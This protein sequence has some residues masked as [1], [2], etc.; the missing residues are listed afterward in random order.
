MGHAIESVEVTTV[1]PR[2][3]YRCA[4]NTITFIV[5]MSG[6]DFIAISYT[7]PYLLSFIYGT[8][9]V[10]SVFCILYSVFCILRLEI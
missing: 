8:C 9:S 7:I 3:Q 2:V 4:I 6:T 1:R 10:S 5:D